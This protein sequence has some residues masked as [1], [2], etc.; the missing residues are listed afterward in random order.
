MG[1][2]N[3]Q[4]YR[5]TFNPNRP[6]GLGLNPNRSLDFGLNPNRSSDFGK[7]ARLCHAACFPPSRRRSGLRRGVARNRMRTKAGKM[8]ES[9]SSPI[10]NGHGVSDDRFGL[11]NTPGRISASPAEKASMERENPYIRVQRRRP[12]RWSSDK[13]SSTEH[14]PARIL[15][16]K[17][18]FWAALFQ[19]TCR[20]AHSY[21]QSANKT[22]RNPGLPISRPWPSRH[23]PPSASLPPPFPI[24][25][26]DPA[27]KFQ[28][29][30]RQ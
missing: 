8:P 23:R 16:W 29:C 22:G 13:E 3:T 1:L 6:S 21:A 25:G 12:K 15:F 24:G 4:T 28:A 20:H 19:G 7:T 2:Q 14:I 9:L 11:N 18:D 17:T 5:I 27:T 26:R 30:Y 10:R